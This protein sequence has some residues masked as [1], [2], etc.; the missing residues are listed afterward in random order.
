MKVSTCSKLIKHSLLALLVT[1]SMLATASPS[2]E[3]RGVSGTLSCGGNHFIRD[4]GT[5]EQS[6]IFVIRNMDSSLPISINRL[7]IYN[8]VGNV[9]IEHDGATLPLAFNS[10][11]GNGDNV[12]EPFQT[13]QYRTQELIGAP[14]ATAE[15]PIQTRIEWSA[16]AKAIVP[17]VT[18]VRLARTIETVLTNNGPVVRT[19]GERSRNSSRCRN[20]E[21][22]KGNKRG[23]D[24]D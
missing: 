9:I 3:P 24:E 7:T 16:D 23:H 8:A 1:S 11:I 19:R 12:I 4:R 17:A 10:V 22:K 18:A 21:I 6:T 13:V 20:I 15:R 14:L 2:E 5:E